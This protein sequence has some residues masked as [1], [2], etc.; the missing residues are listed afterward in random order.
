MDAIS[1]P[2]KLLENITQYRDYVNSLSQKLSI[3][4]IEL[5]EADKNFDTIDQKLNESGTLFLK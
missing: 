5:E 1:F 2:Q 4:R 3:R